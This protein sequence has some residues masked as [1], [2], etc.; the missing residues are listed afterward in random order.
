MG[1]GERRC[2]SNVVGSL[3]EGQAQQRD[4]LALQVPDGLLDLADDGVDRLLVDARG[5]AKDPEVVAQAVG[6]LLQ[7]DDILRQAIAAVTHAGAQERRSDAGVGAHD[8]GDAVD[9]GVGEFG[10]ARQARWRT[11]PWWR[12][13]R[14]RPAWRARRCADRCGT[15]SRRDRAAAR[16]S[17]SGPGRR[18]RRRRPRPAGRDPGC[19]ARRGPRAGTPDSKPPNTTARAA[20]GPRPWRYAR[21]C[22]AA[23]STSPPAPRRRLALRATSR[24]ASSTAVR[25][26]SPW[27]TGGRPTQMKTA[28]APAT[29]SA[30]EVV[31]DRWPDARP[32]REQLG[33]V[34]FV[35]GRVAARQHGDLVLADVHAHDV[36]A[37]AGERHPGDQSDVAGADDGELHDGRSGSETGGTPWASPG[38]WLSAS[39]NACTV[40]RSPSS[41]PTAGS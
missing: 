23:R 34:G 13:T 32:W 38:T 33:Q 24:A 20:P 14:S 9:V 31:N 26:R 18:G 10:H 7:R 2:P 17:R 41:M 1:E 4:R 11:R 35:E 16:R 5:L 25:L 36:V 12:G 8:R 37:Q 19:P 6:H 28:W 3:L 21:W 29:A 40:R 15:A 39:R 22:P 27:P 30:I